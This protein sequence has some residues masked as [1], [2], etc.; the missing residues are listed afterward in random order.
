MQPRETHTD[1]KATIGQWIL[2]YSSAKRIREVV[3][4]KRASQG[5]RQ[6]QREVRAQKEVLGEVEKEG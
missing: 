1:L 3:M 4:I 6:K 5:A 2:Y